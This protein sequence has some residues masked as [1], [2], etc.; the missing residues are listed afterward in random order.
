[1]T[2]AGRNPTAVRRALGQR[3]RAL[4]TG[5]ELT[6]AQAADLVG[7]SQSKV[8]K[9]ELAQLKQSREDVL[10][11][12]DAYEETDP[13][14]RELLLSMVR[15]GKNKDWWEGHLRLLPKFGS[16]LGLESIATTVQAYDTHLVH[17]LLQTPDYARA[18]IRGT[19]PE[20]LEHEID[21][22][23][24]SRLRRQE[25]LT[26]TDPSPLTLWWI[27]DEAV[28]RRQIGGRETM[29]AQLQRL[30]QVSELP[31]VTLLVMPDE[32][33]A[34]PGLDGPLAILQFE[35][36]TRP[37]VYIEAQAGNLYM[38]KD[39][40]LRR[41]QQTMNHILAAAPGPEH[42]LAL[43]RQAAKEMKP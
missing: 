34:H 29:H 14:Q 24:Q 25:I 4:R 5:R 16:Y 1:M 41:C 39:D 18:V 20:L 23:V 6:V 32:L 42:S 22:L 3:L 40:D 28:L 30:I 17:G 27:M 12:L 19:R 43:I 15:D 10:K 26:R 8:T 37:V 11:L 33:G 2:E 21:Q 35:T 9:I 38:E 13:Q 36:G 31:N 7:I